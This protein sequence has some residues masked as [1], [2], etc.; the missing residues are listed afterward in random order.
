MK[1]NENRILSHRLIYSQDLRNPKAQRPFIIDA[2]GEVYKSSER[3]I[4][5]LRHDNAVYMA[6]LMVYKKDVQAMSTIS[7]LLAMLKTPFCFPSFSRIIS[8][9]SLTPHTHPWYM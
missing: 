4:F 1:G 9:S 7:T 6:H 2:R 8:A 3:F 5:I